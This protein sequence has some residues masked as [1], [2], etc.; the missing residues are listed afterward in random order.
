MSKLS[1]NIRNFRLLRGYTQR[2]FGEL[3]HKAPNTIANW[4]KNVSSPDVDILEDM[5]DILK[6]TPNQLYGWDECAEL[7]SFIKDQQL[8][9]EKMNELVEE[10]SKLDARIKAY[11]DKIKN[12][13]LQ[14]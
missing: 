8:N 4:E 9:I 6:I 13:R 5:C 3:L 14:N 12:V 11:A 7:D 2:E 10:R 1:E